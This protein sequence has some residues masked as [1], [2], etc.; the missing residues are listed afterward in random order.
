MKFSFSPG[1]GLFPGRQRIPKEKDRRPLRERLRQ[2]GKRRIAR[3]RQTMLMFG[4][5]PILGDLLYILHQM[6]TTPPETYALLMKTMPVMAEN[7]TAAITVLFCGL[8]CADIA[9]RR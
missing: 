2:W 1:T 9:A 8:L 3:P 6:R 7:L 5:P 4:L